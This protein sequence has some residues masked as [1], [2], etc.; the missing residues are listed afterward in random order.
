MFESEEAH[1]AEEVRS[2]VLPSEYVPVALSDAVP[3]IDTDAGLG[4]T[5]I[6]VRVGVPEPLGVFCTP[7]HATSSKEAILRI[8]VA[9]LPCTE[10]PPSKP[11][12]RDVLREVVHREG[13][14]SPSVTKTL[15]K[16]IGT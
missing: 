14:S 16:A 13:Q 2:C 8:Q 4:E 1:C 6:F 3:E 9:R 12:N 7:L 10:T 11:L 5:E 15:T